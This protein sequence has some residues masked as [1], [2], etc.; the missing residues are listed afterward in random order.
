MAG[1]VLYLLAGVMF[2]LFILDVDPKLNFLKKLAARK[3]VINKKFRLENHNAETFQN[4]AETQGHIH[5]HQ[6]NM[7]G[8][9]VELGGLTSDPV[10]K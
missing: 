10:G 8:L 9:L 6:F 5:E 4:E 2:S 1:F 3:P 7:H